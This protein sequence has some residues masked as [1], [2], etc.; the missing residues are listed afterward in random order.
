MPKQKNSRPFIF[1]FIALILALYGLL[2]LSA[3]IL[4][5]FGTGFSGYAGLIASQ[6]NI[7][8]GNFPYVFSIVGSIVFILLSLGYFFASYG[9]LKLKSWTHLTFYF[10]SFVGLLDFLLGLYNK[11][12]V[13]IYQ[14]F[15]VFIYAFFGYYISMNRELFKK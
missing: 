14:L 2:I 11:S 3:S 15:V 6:S 1:K 4:T 13:A 12:P 7:D 8:M 9:L 5:L 10:L